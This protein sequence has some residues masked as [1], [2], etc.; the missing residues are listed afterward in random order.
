M[1]LEYKRKAQKSFRTEMVCYFLFYKFYFEQNNGFV[2]V[3]NYFT[4]QCLICHT[5]KWSTHS[6][7]KC[8]LFTSLNTVEEI[9]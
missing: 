1:R 9:N 4:L 2:F 8:H 5:N 3:L 6:T 7:D